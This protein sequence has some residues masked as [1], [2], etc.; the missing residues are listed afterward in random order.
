MANPAHPADRNRLADMDGDGDLDAIIGY[1]GIS[2]ERLVAWYERPNNPTALWPEHLIGTVVGPQSL[3]VGDLDD[4]GDL[5]VVIGEHNLQAPG[6]GRVVVFENNAGSWQQYV[7]AT[8]DEHHDGTQL[9]DIDGDGDLDIVS[10]GWSHSEVL[11]YEHLSCP[12]QPTATPT[13]TS[14]STP[15]FTPTP[16]P[17]DTPTAIPDEPE[18]TPT[19]TDTPTAIP[20][21]P[22]ATPTPTDTPTAT[23]DEPE[24]TPSA[25]PTMTPSA[26][27]TMTPSKTP[28]ATPSATPAA[29]P[30]FAQT[31][32]LSMANDGAA[33]GVAFADEDI[34][35]FDIRTS[36][37]ALHL[38]GSDIGL[39]KTDVDALFLMEDGSFLLSL[40]APLTISGIGTIAD[41]DILRFVPTSLGQDTAGSFSLYFD[42]SDVGL[43]ANSEDVNTIAVIDEGLL[44]STLGEA[45]VTGATAND[46]DLLLF[47]PTRLGATTAGTWSR[48]L[49]GGGLG[50]SGGGEELLA[51]ML[52]PANEMFF[53]ASD[54]ATLGS[55][56]VSDDDIV[57]CLLASAGPNTACQQGPSIVWRATQHGLVG[58]VIDGLMVLDE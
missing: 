17:T 57:Y 22:E 47:R 26:T 3:D 12:G 2:V 27:P 46:E 24:A 9:S 51:A 14:T 49:Y 6:T 34:L 1:E 4:D 48:Y 5:D 58:H 44:L 21:E 8:G 40:G 18:A 33:G 43:K 35:R 19:P 41:A 50:L 53:V 37:W 15:S 39:K 7:V 36:T 28:T 10:I 42:G 52:T 55:L 29:T 45:S 32:L 11:L 23:P 38:D 56:T 25:T 20:D 16:T 13:P 31:L 54:N 30:Q